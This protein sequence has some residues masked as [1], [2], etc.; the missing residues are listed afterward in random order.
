[1]PR[2]TNRRHQRIAKTEVLRLAVP[3]HSSPIAPKTTLAPAR[4]NRCT[5]SKALTRSLGRAVAPQTLPSVIRPPPAPRGARRRFWPLAGHR[6]HRRVPVG[7]VVGAHDVRRAFAA[8]NE[9]STAPLRSLPPH[10]R[11]R[12]W[13]R[14]RRRRILHLTQRQLDVRRPSRPTTSATARPPSLRVSFSL[15]LPSVFHDRVIEECG[16]KRVQ[17]RRLGFRM[18]SCN[19]SKT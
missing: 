14:I 16:E 11:Q 18:I 8:R 13:G 7:S 15:A 19:R 12:R 6:L 4:C 5:R 1:L 2:K 9:R 10:R 17:M 3:Q